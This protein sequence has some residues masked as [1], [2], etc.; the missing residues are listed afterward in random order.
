MD[1][2]KTIDFTSIC[3]PTTDNSDTSSV[4]SSLESLTSKFSD[5]LMLEFDNMSTTTMVS[6]DTVS[7]ADI[8]P[9]LSTLQSRHG[10]DHPTGPTLNTRIVFTGD[11]VQNFSIQEAFQ[12]IFNVISPHINICQYC[13]SIR[14][15]DN[16]SISGESVSYWD[17]E[18][19]FKGVNLP[20]LAIVLFLNENNPGGNSSVEQIRTTFR[21][22]PWRLHHQ[23]YVSKANVSAS[24]ENIPDYYFITEDLP[25]CAVRQIHMGKKHLRFVRFVRHETWQ[26]MVD[27]YCLITGCKV[28]VIRPDFCLLTT[29]TRQEYNVQ[30]ALKKIPVGIQSRH[31]KSAELIFNVEHIGSLVPLLPSMCKAVSKTRW[32]TVDVDNNIIYFDSSCNGSTF[33]QSSASTPLNKTN[34][35]TCYCHISENSL[36]HHPIL[37]KHS[38]PLGERRK[39]PRSKTSNSDDSS[40]SCL[41]KTLR[42]LMDPNISLSTVTTSETSRESID[43][44][45]LSTSDSDTGFR[46]RSDSDSLP[47][48]SGGWPPIYVRRNTTSVDSGAHMGP[49]YTMRKPTKEEHTYDLHNRLRPSSRVGFHV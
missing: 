48:S 42:A 25:L 37:L 19:D 10:E 28:E 6:E 31:T 9:T 39:R 47:D 49:H 29:D 30:L 20:S 12:P 34:M 14:F 32:Q 46:T 15:D 1:I 36:Q 33:T 11:S 27:F 16:E 44:E 26:D 21:N 40:L 2:D 24:P 17:E 13:H 43:S 7:P 45:S 4:I 3:T 41:E 23:D 35:E 38:T 22:K 18:G 5:V 8:T